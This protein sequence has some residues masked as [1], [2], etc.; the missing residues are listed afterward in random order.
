MYTDIHTAILLFMYLCIQAFTLLFC[1][2]TY[3]GIHTAVLLL[4]YIG[5]HTAILLFTYLCIQVFILLF[6]C[7]MYTGIHTAVLLFIYTGIHHSH[8]SSAVYVYR[9][10]HC[11]SAVYVY[12][13]SHRYSAE[14]YRHSHCCLCI[15]AFTL[16]F[17]CLCI[18]AFTLLYCCLCIQEYQSHIKHT[19]I[20]VA[21]K[22]HTND[23]PLTQFKFGVLRFISGGAQLVEYMVV[24]LI[25]SLKHHPVEKVHLC[26]TPL[27]HPELETPHC[28]KSTSLCYSSRPA[29]ETPPCGKKYISVLLLSSCA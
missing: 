14:L 15:Q 7:T 19:G 23:T 1:C 4:M 13:H 2:I 11:Y 27:S 24:P 21:K 12:K 10:S 20:Q 25:L 26:V 29:L 5:I 28:G 17:C 16:L 18:Q 22:G 3:T 8:C 6:C 9:H